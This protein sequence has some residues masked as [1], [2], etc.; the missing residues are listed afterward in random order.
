MRIVIG[1]ALLAFAAA[2]ADNPKPAVMNARPPVPPASTSTTVSASAS[3]GA[4]QGKTYLCTS[5][6]MSMQFVVAGDQYETRNAAKGARSGKG[7]LK[8][9]G[10]KLTPLT[11][12][13][14]GQ[15]GTRTKTGYE[16]EA[17]LA[18]AAKPLT[19]KAG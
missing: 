8:I 7:K 16:F 4:V 11:G 10:D 3:S 17:E 14:V 1:L 19:C 5:P 2:C 15:V 13:L 6:S 18:G 9:S 12:P